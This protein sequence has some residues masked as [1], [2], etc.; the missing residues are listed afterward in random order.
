MLGRLCPR[1]TVRTAVE[2]EARHRSAEGAALELRPTLEGFVDDSASRSTPVRPYR[3]DRRPAGG[4]N[5]VSAVKRLRI[6]PRRTIIWVLAVIVILMVAF[7]TR[8]YAV[9]TFSIPSG[10]MS[11]TLQIGDRITVDKLHSTIQRGDI[12]VFQRVPADTEKQDADLVKRVIGLP[13][14][15]I[16]ST[17]NTVLINGKALAEPWLPPLMGVCAETSANI[18]PT[19][20][21]PDHY[22]V[23]GDCRGDSFDSRYWG[24]VPAPSSSARSTP[25]SGVAAILGSTGSDRAP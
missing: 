23:M 3:G 24:T 17:G 20:V 1:R 6:L 16:S 15:T 9:E 8:A 25:S 7:A 10:S 22:F 2:H 18:P 13:G 19:T 12:V 4:H 11:P 5:K 21:P 14:E